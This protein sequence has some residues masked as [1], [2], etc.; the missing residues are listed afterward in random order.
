[1][2][3]QIEMTIWSQFKALMAIFLAKGRSIMTISLF[4]ND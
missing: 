4:A 3:N 2:T 1:M